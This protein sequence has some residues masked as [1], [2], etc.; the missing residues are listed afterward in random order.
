MVCFGKMETAGWQPTLFCIAAFGSK[1]FHLDCWSGSWSG[2]SILTEKVC[3][4]VRWFGP[5]ALGSMFTLSWTPHFIDKAPPSLFLWGRQ[6]LLLPWGP[7]FKSTSS[8]LCRCILTFSTSVYYENFQS[9]RKTLRMVQC[10]PIQYIHLSVHTLYFVI[11]S[12]QE[13]F[14]SK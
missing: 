9:Y 10:I 13:S 8:P 12:Y 4:G 1:I 11:F 6:E 7:L 2:S 3:L 14:N 5:R